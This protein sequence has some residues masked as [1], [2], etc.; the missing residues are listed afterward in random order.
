MGCSNSKSSTNV[1]STPAPSKSAPATK[2]PA[3]AAAKCPATKLCDDV[4]AGKVIIGYWNIKGRAYPARCLLA[5]A[6]V[7]FTDRQY[8]NRLNKENAAI[9][10]ENDKP[11]LGKMAPMNF[12]SIPYVIDPTKKVD[13]KPT[14]VFQSLAVQRYLGRRFG[15]CAKTDSEIALEDMFEGVMKDIMDGVGKAFFGGEEA[16][17]KWV[18]GFEAL[19]KPLDAHLASNKYLAGDNV[20]C[21]DFILFSHMEMCELIVKDGMAKFPNLTTFRASLMENAGLRKY[22]ESQKDC[23]FFP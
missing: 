11:E 17:A 8:D 15:L 1:A 2:K 9:W 19:F 14:I 22:V 20:T 4:K 13:G 7:D 3:A 16:M 18:E 5:Y 10:F 6:G 23:P 21:F 12:P